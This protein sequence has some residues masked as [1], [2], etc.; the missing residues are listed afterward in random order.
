M[1]GVF[2]IFPSTSKSSHRSA[3]ETRQVVPTTT[4]G[5]RPPAGKLENRTSQLIGMLLLVPVLSTMIDF[6]WAAIALL[7]VLKGPPNRFG[8]HFLLGL[9]LIVAAPCR[10]PDG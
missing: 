10:R 1:R 2:P 8:D 6:S 3:E 4:I 5:A 9:R 7:I